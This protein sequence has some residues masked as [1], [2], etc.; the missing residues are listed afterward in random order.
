MLRLRAEPKNEESLDLIF[1]AETIVSPYQ[2]TGESASGA[3]RYGL[4][5]GRAVA[6]IPLAIFDDVS[7]AVFRL[8]GFVPQQIADGITEIFNGIAKNLWVHC[9]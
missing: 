7:L 8:P 4:A 5:S 1:E 3:V 2:E 9:K 6:V